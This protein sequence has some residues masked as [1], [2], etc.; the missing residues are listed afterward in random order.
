[1]HTVPPARSIRCTACMLAGAIALSPTAAGAGPI[2]HRPVETPTALTL[3]PMSLWAAGSAASAPGQGILD[4][5]R[6]LADPNSEDEGWRDI[7]RYV[8]RYTDRPLVLRPT[9]EHHRRVYLWNDPEGTAYAIHE[10][11]DLFPVTEPTRVRVRDADPETDHIEVD[12]ESTDGRR[13]RVSFYGREPS[14]AVFR[15]WMDEIFETETPERNF[16]RYFADTVTGVLH[17]RGSEHRLPEDEREVVEDP[18]DAVASRFKRCMVC[19]QP[20]PRVED[21][22][23]EEDLQERGLASV[24]AEFRIS[25]DRVAHSVLQELGEEVL[26]A[27]PAPLKGYAYEFLLVE[28]PMVNAF[29]LPGGRVF[30]TSGLIE[31][32]DN[33]AALKAILAH[34]V[35]HVESRHSYRAAAGREAASA[36]GGLLD[37]VSQTTGNRRIAEI[38]AARMTGFTLGLLN[39][40][41]DREREADMFASVMFGRL[42][43]STDAVANA[44]QTLR[45]IEEALPPRASNSATDQFFEGLLASHPSIYERLDRAENT[46]TGSFDEHYWTF[47]GLNSRGT[48]VATV[49]FELQQAFFDEVNALVSIATTDAL[50]RRDN[51]NDIDIHLVDGTRLD[52]DEQTA[53]SVEPGQTVSALFSTDDA[54]GL[55]EAVP[56]QMRLRLRN[57][58]RW[59]RAQR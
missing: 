44:F 20:P 17:A 56:Q 6:R 34:D 28:H 52:F 49:R 10:G 16:T 24:R 36:I 48:L 55:V 32:I 27:W 8:E 50:G 21:W 29:A 53:E 59:Q 22:D 47:H 18:T 5:L 54:D 40:D 19:F 45:E 38:G 46:V 30:V 26:A 1:M 4:R 14:V 58:D 23:Y 13:G 57:V 39:Y 7:E 15:S 9:R 51:I 33:E 12:L 3:H 11:D 42:S 43:Q 37:V 35:G 25:Q 31:A 41:R 2:L